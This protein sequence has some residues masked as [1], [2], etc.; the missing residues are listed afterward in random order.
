MTCLLMTDQSDIIPSLQSLALCCP[1]RVEY[2]LPLLSL[3]LICDMIN[4]RRD[5]INK[6]EEVT[7]YR[8]CSCDDKPRPEENTEMP[9][10]FAPNNWVTLPAPAQFTAVSVKSR[11]V[12]LQR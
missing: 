6:A 9:D 1:L 8:E 11:D 3:Q 7:R 4:Q 10:I 12:L 2:S 5:P